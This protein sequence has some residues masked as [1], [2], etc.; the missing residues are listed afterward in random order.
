MRAF[1]N[2]WT[3]KSS[4]DFLGECPCQ[5]CL[6]AANCFMINLTSICQKKKLDN[7]GAEDPVGGW[8][9]L[10]GGELA[11]IKR[12]RRCCYIEEDEPIRYHS[13]SLNSEELEGIKYRRR[14]RYT[15][16]EREEVAANRK[17]GACREC[18]AR[19]IRV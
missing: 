4:K 16:E 5:H 15:E 18:K 6:Q 2:L 1:L 9:S 19:K 7:K 8:S 10:N 12:L 3:D 11:D 14:R 17:R 13:F